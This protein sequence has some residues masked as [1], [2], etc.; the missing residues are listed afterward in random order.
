MIEHLTQSVYMLEVA[1]AS[2]LSAVLP[3]PACIMVFAVHTYLDG[4]I[5]GVFLYGFKHPTPLLL[6]FG[7]NFVFFCS[8]G[9]L[10]PIA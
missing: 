5:S 2:A 10:F 1:D 8:I 7:S 3:V 4:L 9:L 6:L